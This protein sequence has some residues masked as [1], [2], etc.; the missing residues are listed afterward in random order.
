MHATLDQHWTGKD[1]KSF[2]ADLKARQKCGETASWRT[3]CDDQDER[4]SRREREGSWTRDL[5]IAEARLGSPGGGPA[6]HRTGHGQVQ[7]RGPLAGGDSSRL[8]TSRPGLATPRYD[9]G[10]TMLPR[11]PRLLS[12]SDSSLSVKGVCSFDLALPQP[13]NIPFFFQLLAIMASCQ[14]GAFQYHNRNRTLPTQYKN[15][16]VFV[17]LT[18]LP[19][20]NAATKSPLLLDPS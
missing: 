16:C 14:S 4:E 6:R 5:G 19:K 18:L 20:V 8:A 13:V 9:D 11:G 10:T 1:L 3:H 15:L 7:V 2:N 17:S 12:D